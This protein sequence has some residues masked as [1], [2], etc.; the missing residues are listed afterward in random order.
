MVTAHAP[1]QSQRHGISLRD[2]FRMFP[3]DEAA[4]QWFELAR[5]GGE[6]WCPHCGSTNVQSGAKHP[7]MP[8]RCR[9]KG[10]AKRFSV[11][12]KT[13]LQDSKLGYQTWAIAI[14]LAT[15][16]L[17]G[18]SSMKLHRDLGITQ[19]SAWHLAHRIRETWGDDLAPFAGPV[20]ADET[21]IGGKERNKHERDRLH[22]GR[23]PVGKTA[24]VGAKDRE[25]GKV[26]ARVIGSVDRPTLHGFV[27]DHVAR[28]ATLYTDEAVA[29]RGVRM[30]HETVAHSVGEYVD[31]MA[32]TNGIESFWSMLKRGYQGTYHQMSPKHLDRYVN[33]FA[34]RH[35]IRPLDTL[36]Q[37]ADVVRGFEGKRLTY[38]E[39]IEA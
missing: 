31:G 15:T 24:V 36:Q 9:E 13:P 30:N 16:S 33:E 11:R 18:V 20:E 4:R 25:T 14:Y 1:G 19:K 8:Y 3:D 34:G 6:P 32:H 5:W 17:K 28:G 37:M 29:Y 22:A 38:A 27:E 26:A 2:L 23:G 21:Y 7:S 10:C 12:I 35:N 39:L